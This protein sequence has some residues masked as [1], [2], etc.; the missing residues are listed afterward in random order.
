M[1]P[2]GCDRADTSLAQRAHQE[3]LLDRAAIRRNA[4]RASASYD[5]YA[6]LAGRLREQMI[7]R[8]GWI[9]FDPEVVLDLGCGTGHAAMALGSRWPKA[10]VI[11]LDVSP[12]MLRETE[13]RDQAGRCERLCADA[14][15]A[16]AGCER[17][18]RLQQPAAALVRGSRRALRAKSR[19]CCA[20]AACSRSRPSGRT[21]SAELRDAWAQADDGTHVHPFTDMHDI[22][23]G[24]I[25]AGLVEPVLD[26]SPL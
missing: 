11:A 20:R 25:R 14:R 21:R 18:S 2:R 12:G 13:R 16:A 6:V 26:V 23:D 22:G 7:E 5:E 1:L 10:R 17:G 8:L 24:L 19:A 3:L 4:D 15:R 9:A